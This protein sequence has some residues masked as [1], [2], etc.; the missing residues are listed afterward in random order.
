MRLLLPT[1]LTHTSTHAQY[2]SL[3]FADSET[4]DLAGKNAST[5]ESAIRDAFAKPFPLAE[6]IRLTFVTGAGKLARQKYDDGAA[7][8]ITVALRDYSYQEDQSGGAGTFKLQHDTGK[9]L[10][11][12]VV[13]PLVTGSGPGNDSSNIAGAMGGVSLAANANSLIPDGTPEHK[14]AHAST[15]VFQRMIASMCPSWS[16]KKG[17]VAKIDEIKAMIKELD[18]KLLTGTPLDDAEQALYDSVSMTALDEKQA[19]VREL[20][21][22]QVDGGEITIAERKVL[23]SQVQE[24]I[25]ALTKDLDEVQTMGKPA[26]RIETLTMALA[27]V[28][29]RLEKISNIVPKPLAK[30]KNEAQIVKLRTEMIPL[31]EIEASTGQ[32]GQL[33]SIKDTQAIAR[34]EEI[35]E[36][37]EALEVSFSLLLYLFCICLLLIGVWP[38]R[39]SPER[40][41]H[42]HC[43]ELWS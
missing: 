25:A 1:I 35:E 24:K 4:F 14:I 2:I 40:F 8:A 42:S 33:R 6:T 30:L 12:V 36:E 23:L 43:L 38:A 34:K 28:Q 13:H 22:A 26:K 31:A 19:H 21:Q 41:R 39:S 29:A 16:Q 15:N 37:I 32:R 11:T 17:C 10:K 27:K 20:M 3:C 9:N 18:D 5:I 7:K